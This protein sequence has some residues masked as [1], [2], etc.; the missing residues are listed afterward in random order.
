MDYYLDPLPIY[1]LGSEVLFLTLNHHSTSI[2]ALLTTDKID[3]CQMK[4]ENSSPEICN[5][6]VSFTC[7]EIKDGVK[8]LKAGKTRGPDL[9]LNEFIKDGSNTLVLT[10]TKLFNKILNSGFI[11]IFVD[12][13]F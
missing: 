13:C 2:K 3:E 6:D 5:L 8:R 12:N 10:L 11:D 9:I 7:K 4:S 1:R